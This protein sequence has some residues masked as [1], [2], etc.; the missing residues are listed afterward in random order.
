MLTS[1]PP[2]YQCC[3]CGSERIGNTLI[4]S[5]DFAGPIWACGECRAKNKKR[6]IGKPGWIYMIGYDEWWKVGFTTKSPAY[7]VRELQNGNPHLLKLSGAKM[8]NDCLV[9][10][11][12]IH[13][14]LSEFHHRGEW[15]HGP[16]EKI[17]SIINLDK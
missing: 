13:R 5:C 14:K 8:V 3:Y 4:R 15:F 9:S 7:R 16:E 12:F 11:L 10:E 17:R 6:I 2:I 1:Y